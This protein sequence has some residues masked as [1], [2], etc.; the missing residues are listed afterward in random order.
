MN[1]VALSGSR[2]KTEGEKEEEA[3]PCFVLAVT[4]EKKREASIYKC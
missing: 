4:K 2:G 1:T 3:E